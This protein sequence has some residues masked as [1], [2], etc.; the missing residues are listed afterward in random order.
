M[1]DRV[2]FK[3]AVLSLSTGREVIRRHKCIFK[4]DGSE[5]RCLDF[6][7]NFDGGIR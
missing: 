7:I 4:K 2:Q 3:G 1:S 5:F 6:K